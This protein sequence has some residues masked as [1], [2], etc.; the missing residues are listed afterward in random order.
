LN[1][2][3]RV[4]GTYQR[5]CTSFSKI[6][7]VLNLIS[8][9]QF[10]ALPD[11]TL[12]LPFAGEQRRYVEVAPLLFQQIDR[13]DVLLFRE[14]SMGQVDIAFSNEYPTFAF[15]RFPWYE[16]LSF[17]KT[18]LGIGILLLISALIASIGRVLRRRKTS[19][20]ASRWDRLAT[21]GL[22]MGVVFVLLFIIFFVIGFANPKAYNQG[23]ASIFILALLC[24][25]L[26]VIATVVIAISAI[27]LW[28]AKV[29]SLAARIHHTL[30]A[31]GAVALVWVFATWNL[32]GWRK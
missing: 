32:I 20:E 5:T 19:T 16:N 24:S 26:F 27:H 21:F 8:S 10:T 25:T 2:A 30:V 28:C 6:E 29:W 22:V 13:D 1:N 12:T 3:Q 17:H 7:K 15:Q 9:W 4:A 31:L 23:H 18:V 14:N 11:G